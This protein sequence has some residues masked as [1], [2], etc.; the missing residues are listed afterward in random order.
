MGST[1]RPNPWFSIRPWHLLL[2]L[3]LLL[4]LLSYQR[5]LRSGV[6][7]ED[8]QLLIA[9]AGLRDACG[10][11]DGLIARGQFEHGEA[12]VEW[13]RP[14]VAAFGDCA[15]GRDECRRHGFID[16]AAEDIN[17]GGF[18]LIDHRVSVAAYRLPLAVGHDHRRAGKGN[19]I[20]GHGAQDPSHPLKGSI[21]PAP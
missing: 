3:L 13:R 4:A 20:L 21:G 17:A 8:A 15:I 18:R 14:W 7:P 1:G 19:Q 2:L 5:R 9:A 11:R 12:A 6:E 10:P 16:S